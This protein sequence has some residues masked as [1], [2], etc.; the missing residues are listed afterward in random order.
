MKGLISSL[1][2][3]FK[4]GIVFA[5]LSMIVGIAFSLLGLGASLQSLDNPASIVSLGILAIIGVVASIT[6]TGILVKI[7]YEKVK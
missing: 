4:R 5:V 3:G 6:I 2:Q 1:I 7:V